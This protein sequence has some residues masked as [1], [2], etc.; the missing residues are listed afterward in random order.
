MDRERGT[1]RK[2]EGQRE[3]GIVAQ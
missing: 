2:K 1:R 3:S